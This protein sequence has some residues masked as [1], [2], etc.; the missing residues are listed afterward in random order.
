[1]GDWRI[2]R[3]DNGHVRS[4]FDCGKPKL[5]DFL[6]SLVSQYEKRDLGR[7]FVA[8]EE[9]DQRVKGYY[10]LASG[11]IGV[12]GLPAKEAKKL[13]RHPVPIVLLARLAVDV[14]AQRRG[15]GGALLRD[16][17]GRSVAISES[18]GTFAVVVD[19]LDEEANAFYEKFGFLPLTD[20]PMR[21]F[22]PLGTIRAVGGTPRQ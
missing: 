9:I 5:N 14:S 22:L 12:E 13:P 18:L 1:V 21:L 3:L 15:L 10:T 16:A 20:N 4:G 7:T 19:A 6:H 11:A 8:L 17:L 2:E